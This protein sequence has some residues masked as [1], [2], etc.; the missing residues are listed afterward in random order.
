MTRE[1]LSLVEDEVKLEV[2]RLN[3]ENCSSRFI[4]S[5]TGISKTAINDF[6][7][8]KSFKDFWESYEDKPIASGEL[9]SPE[10]HHKKLEG[11][12]F[13]ITSAQNNTYVFRNGFETLK[14]F[15]EHNDAELIVGTFTYNKNGFQNLNKEA[16][17]IWYDPY[18]IPYINNSSCELADGLIFFGELNIL[19]T[20]VD[21]LSGLENYSKSSSG[22]VPHAKLQLKSCPRPKYDDP[23]FLYTTGTITKRNYI[24]QKSGQKAGFHHVYSA[25][26]VEID[27][28]GEWF[29]RQFVLDENGH[30]HDLDKLYTPTD[31]YDQQRVESITFGDVHVEKLDQ[32][33]YEA[34]IEDKDSMVKS[35]KPKNIFIHDLIDFSA[36]N[37]HNI[38]D[39]DHLYQTF[40]SGNDSVEVEMEIAANFLENLLDKSPL[41]SKILVVES[42]HHQALNNWLK[43]ADYRNDPVNAV[44]FLEL[45]LQK[46]KSMREGLDI[47]LFE[48]AIKPRMSH[49]LEDEII[50]LREDESYT[51]CDEDGK[52]IECSYHGHRGI[53]GA[54]GSIESFVRMN[55]RLNVGHSH[56]ASIKDGVYV[57]GHMTDVRLMTYAKGP[58]TW[59]HSHIVTYPNGKRSIFTIKNGKY[60][61][62]K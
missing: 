2:I 30:A 12:R 25:L 56:T 7:A 51:I 5:Y 23:K 52:G 62:N 3:Q 27:S 44:Y 6:L 45:Q 10:T 39:P 59:S 14:R 40:I 13:L 36:K 43:T 18:V 50:F 19:P 21:P 37:H 60:K 22:I 4:S 54:R 55:S 49:G 34:S 24:Q 47:D 46:Y 11:K 32:G 29:V 57:A 9:S 16:D 35:L 38:N 8:K 15:C 20:A 26:I 28:D 17:G 48:Q 33:V 31:V 58:S 41:D 42:N 53:G 61:A 1:T